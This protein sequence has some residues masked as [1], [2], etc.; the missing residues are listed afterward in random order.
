MAA[1]LRPGLPSR[2]QSFDVME[3]PRST[4]FNFASPLPFLQSF[5]SVVRPRPIKSLSLP[6]LGG[7]SSLGSSTSLDAA[8]PP[9]VPSMPLPMPVPLPILKFVIPKRIVTPATPVIDPPV[10]SYSSFPSSGPSG[11]SSPLLSDDSGTGLGILAE[12]LPPA[13]PSPYP[14][15]DESLLS[16]NR[17]PE[18]VKHP[19]MRRQSAPAV[20]A[21]QP[22]STLFFPWLASGRGEDACDPLT[23]RIQP[24]TPGAS[25]ST[26]T[27]APSA[28]FAPLSH[29]PA[30]STSDLELDD[31]NGME[32]PSSP[33]L[34]NWQTDAELDHEADEEAGEDSP[35]SPVPRPLQSA[36]W[37][38]YF[39]PPSRTASTF[40]VGPAVLGIAD[41]SFPSVSA[42]G[43]AQHVA[44]PFAASPLGP[45]S[46]DSL[47]SPLT[48]AD[49]DSDEDGGCPSYFDSP[50][51]IRSHH[52]TSLSAQPPTSLSLRRTSSDSQL[53][54][55]MAADGSRRRSSSDSHFW[56][57]LDERDRERERR[58]SQTE[59]IESSE[60]FVKGRRGGSEA[61]LMGVDEGEE[62]GP[63]SPDSPLMSPNTPIS[64]SEMEY[65]ALKKVCPVLF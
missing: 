30:S 14:T 31:R 9:P 60:T 65:F 3:S 34:S 39:S 53:W 15:Y 22:P 52:R 24:P 61:G 19:R 7:K 58:G 59:R 8:L 45:Y 54:A 21:S 51:T 6:R 20:V 50:R 11:S 1:S 2:S 27:P 35:G 49:Y 44:G 46:V 5:P 64:P 43:G 28:A 33:A 12:P 10:D 29:S 62:R 56:D 25:S 17:I 32:C 41:Y 4:S 55:T 23:I 42:A 40:P 38:T 16:P 13:P 47:D 37:S 36:L 63:M 57:S 26:F 18:H 48:P